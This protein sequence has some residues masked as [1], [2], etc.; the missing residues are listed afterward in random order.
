MPAS[1]QH[2]D[3]DL[4]DGCRRNDN[5]KAVAEASISGVLTKAK[6]APTKGRARLQAKD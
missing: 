1:R 3:I 2:V 6:R 5:G 4:G